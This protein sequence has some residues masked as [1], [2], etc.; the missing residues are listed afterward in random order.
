MMRTLTGIPFSP[1]TRSTTLSSTTRSSLACMA[2][3]MQPISSR[4]IL[5]P[6]A[7]SNFP[8]FFSR[9]PVEDPRS[10]PNS[11]DSKRL[12]GMAAQFMAMKK[13]VR[14]FAF[15]MD[16]ARDQFLPRA[17][18]PVNEDRAVRS[19][20]RFRWFRKVFSWPAFARSGHGRNWL[21]SGLLSGRGSL[22]SGPF[23]PALFQ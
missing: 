17:G 9:A 10:C 4:K 5:P 3:V 8:I 21:P 23:S 13:L 12:S 6:S 19:G 20:R 15:E 18:F 2:A 7:S 22:G 14:P 11:S 16:G 1:P